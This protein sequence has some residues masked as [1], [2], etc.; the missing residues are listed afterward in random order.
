MNELLE[1]L[2]RK[3]MAANGFDPSSF[4]SIIS[5]WAERLS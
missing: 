5:Y 3:D 2:V 4:S 1:D